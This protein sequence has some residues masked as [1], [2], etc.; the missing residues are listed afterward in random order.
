MHKTKSSKTNSSTYSNSSAPNSHLQLAYRPFTSQPPKVSDAAKTSTDIEDVAF[1]EQ[2]MEATGLEIQAKY[3]S[4]TPEGQERLTVLQAK[5]DGL[6]NSRLSHATLFG[7]NI[8]NIPLHRP[9]RPTPIQAKLT[10]GEPGDKYEQEADEIARQVVQ[11]LHQ[12]QGG[13]LQRESLP[14]EEELQM[15][16]M[17]QRATEGG[18]AA[19]PLETSIQ[20][21]QG[22][23]QPLADSIK[24][25][26]ER[27]N[28]SRV[29]QA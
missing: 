4:I 28:L 24:S 18:M 27:H 29:N 21:A 15:K 7:H 25:P 12:P 22:S 10:I 17:V 26:M 23:G 1:A 13:K 2:Q 9:D 5:M 8:A 19:S 3:G 20:Q 11:R 16:S 6:L 14:E